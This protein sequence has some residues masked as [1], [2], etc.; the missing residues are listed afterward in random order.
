MR[1][2]GLDLNLLVVFDALRETESVTGAAQ[3]LNLSQPSISA[4]L[5]RLREYFDDQL[6][7]HVDRRMQPTAR[8]ESLA[9]GITELLNVARFQVCRPE[10]FDA[11]NSRRRFRMIA[12]DYAF[13]ILVGRT[14]SRAAQIAPGIS[15]DVS[16]AG[17]DSYR[18][19]QQGDIDLLITVPS[20]V[21]TE[22]PQEMLYSDVDAVVA[23]KGGK[24][25]HGIDAAQFIQA[26]FAAAVFGA[27][28]RPTVS[29]TFFRSIG[30]ERNIVVQVPSFS[31]L[32]AAISETDRVAVMHRRHAEMFAKF[33]PLVVHDLP[34]QGAN[35]REIA[36]WH[37]LRG[38]DLG[39]Q[40]LLQLLRAEA[41]LLD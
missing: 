27:E 40:W 5:K 13:D 10:K 26:E 31:A 28:R 39:V 14:T 33:Y 15:F 1:F 22:H 21:L 17:A 7:M 19:F 6:F 36:Q 11:A 34:V 12:S 38:E 23:W 9:P 4:A 20:F 8:A 16:Q 35:I 29:E 37:K 3:Q 24:F 18:A 2:E 25:A 30:I 32:P 41:A